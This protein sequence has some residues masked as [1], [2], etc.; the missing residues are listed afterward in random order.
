MVL[1]GLQR[2]LK[3]ISSVV[4]SIKEPKFHLRHTFE[5]FMDFGTRLRCASF[6]L[7]VAYSVK[8]GYN[9]GILSLDPL[10]S[11][12]PCGIVEIGFFII[13]NRRPV[14]SIQLSVEEV[15][16][17]V[18]PRYRME[19]IELRTNIYPRVMLHEGTTGQSGARRKNS[20]GVMPFGRDAHLAIVSYEKDL[21]LAN[22]I[23]GLF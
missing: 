10:W 20:S 2:S 9:L 15:G 13:S 19:I 3:G 16:S 22:T 4:G 21:W 8:Y 1:L 7:V 11:K 6:L 5:S 23:V 18:S 17:R 14:P 12:P